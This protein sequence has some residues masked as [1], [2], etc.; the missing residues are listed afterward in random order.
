MHG[1]YR[2]MQWKQMT[3]LLIQYDELSKHCNEQFCNEM[4]KH[5]PTQSKERYYHMSPQ[6]SGLDFKK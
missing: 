6:T 4:A 5:T 3:V 2:E 1:C